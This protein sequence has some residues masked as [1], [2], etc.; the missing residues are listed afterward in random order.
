MGPEINSI[1]ITMMKNTAINAKGTP[2]IPTITKATL[3][4]LNANFTTMEINSHKK[5]IG[6]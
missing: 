6:I 5:P 4:D 2:G 3:S 1:I